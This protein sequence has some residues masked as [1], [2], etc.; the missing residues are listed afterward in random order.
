MYPQITLKLSNAN[1][2]QILDVAYSETTNTS[3]TDSV[4]TA[5]NGY[6]G[7]QLS[8]RQDAPLSVLDGTYFPFPDEDYSGVIFKEV[9]DEHGVFDTPPSITFTL[10]GQ[11]FDQ[12]NI[13]FD[14]TSEE[15]ASKIEL[16]ISE[17]TYTILNDSML[18]SVD[19]S[20]YINVKIFNS[21]KVTIKFLRWS[22]PYKNT[23][24]MYL[25][26]ANTYV[27]A[28]N[29]INSII[30]S[31]N[32]LNSQ[33]YVQPGIVEQY[34]EINLYDRYKYLRNVIAVNGRLLDGASIKVEMIDDTRSWS[35]GEY[36]INSWDAESN[37]LIA[38]LYAVDP[39]YEFD[40]ISIQSIPA[41]TRSVHELLTK[42]F[43]YA[44]VNSWQ[45]IDSDTREYC[46][47]I[48]IPRSWFNDVTLKKA[49]QNVCAAGMLRIFWKKDNFV[50]M[51]CW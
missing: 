14:Q 28:G 4:T 12:L 35:L 15:Y 7:F 32:A 11:N 48:S 1:S 50:V 21:Y 17:K 16:I 44:N 45:Y 42:L 30:C 38:K 46:S 6:R 24:I 37:S 2:A 27:F 51:R 41:A 29:T 19:L 43:S 33:T 13:A 8:N 49:F 39:S 47:T 20:Q 9:A 3:K 5:V 23:K 36:K 31:E 26:C 40:K 25:S 34:A 10:E 22:A 18:L